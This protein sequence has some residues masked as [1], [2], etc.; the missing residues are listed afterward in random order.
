MIDVKVMEQLK[1]TS[2]F[3]IEDWTTVHVDTC[4]HLY[5][6][7]LDILWVDLH[8]SKYL[9]L[10]YLW[11]ARFKLRK[12]DLQHF[13]FCKRLD[14][15]RYDL[16]YRREKSHESWT[17]S[18][19]GKSGRTQK[20]PNY[21]QICLKCYSNRYLDRSTSTSFYCLF[22]NTYI[23]KGQHELFTIPPPQ[24]HPPDDEPGNRLWP[25]DK[26]CCPCNSG[27][28]CLIQGLQYALFILHLM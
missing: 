24:Y 11:C 28:R 3:I 7:R 5:A 13:V 20:S 25:Y 16:L 21:W 15:R 6:F 27:K 26:N 9:Y 12:V 8:R 1:S 14:L 4:T 23:K 22:P 18:A 2:R 19:S 10:A 17:K